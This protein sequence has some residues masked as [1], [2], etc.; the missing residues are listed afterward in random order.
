MALADSHAG[1]SPARG[2]AAAGAP[3][4]TTATTASA[5][6]TTKALPPMCWP[7]VPGDC[8][9]SE[10]GSCQLRDDRVRAPAVAVPSLLEPVRRDLAQPVRWPVLD[11]IRGAAVMSVV[12]YHVYRLLI[13]GIGGDVLGARPPVWW[14]PLGVAKFTIDVFFVLSG[15]LVVQSWDSI[16]RRAT[17]S[18]SAVREFARR[19]L[20]RVLP[21]WWL[22]LA[23]LVPLVAPTLL[24]SRDGLRELTM[25]VALQQ[26]VVPGLSAHVNTVSWSLTTE[27]HFYA[28][29]PFVA[30]VL[31]RAGRWTFLALAYAV[32]LAWWLAP[33]GHGSPSLL[34]GRIDQFAVGMVIATLVAA[35]QR[36]DTHRVVR[37]ACAPGAWVPA[38]VTIAALGIHHG[39]TFGITSGSLLDRLLHPI[40]G[41]CIGVLVLRVLCRDAERPSA[42]R[43]WLERPVVRGAGL[44]SYSV[45]IWHY[46]LLLWLVRETNLAGAGAAHPLASVQLALVYVALV[47]VIG[48]VSYRLVERPFLS[49][50]ARTTP[51]RSGERLRPPRS[52][53]LARMDGAAV[54]PVSP[55]R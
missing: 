50:P 52:I 20:R 26:Y 42:V 5:A 54:A 6:A 51:A 44:V 21:A 38:V 32:S 7:R 47:T 46:P 25:F 31:R 15:F 30:F 13:G 48:L 16:R 28:L 1:A 33:A 18:A 34:P 11:G 41:V 49:S 55:G 45:Y 53:R 2:T 37:A 19:R 9:E 3:T 12:G 22:S 8:D 35:K 10:S 43:R 27:L 14:W 29:V 24:T 4:G 36:G 23:V 17:S 39:A 40:A